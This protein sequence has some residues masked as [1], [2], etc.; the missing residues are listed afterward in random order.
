MYVWT[1]STVLCLKYTIGSTDL[2]I[3]CHVRN[4]NYALCKVWI[5]ENKIANITCACECENLL[6]IPITVFHVSF[7]GIIFSEFNEFPENR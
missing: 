2:L 1:Y 5:F 4:N 7:T 6:Q 3:S